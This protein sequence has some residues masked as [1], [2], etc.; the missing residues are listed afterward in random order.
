MDTSSFYHSFIIGYDGSKVKVSW[1]IA[2]ARPPGVDLNA[3]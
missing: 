2:L 1:A 3:K